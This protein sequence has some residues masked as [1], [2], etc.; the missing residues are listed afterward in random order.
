MKNQA[1]ELLTKLDQLTKNYQ[2]GTCEQCCLIQAYG[3][4][5]HHRIQK[6]LQQL[7]NEK[8]ARNPTRKVHLSHLQQA[9]SVL[10]MYL[11]V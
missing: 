11:M 6:T 9:A 4:T 2:Q 7:Q 10:G 3:I 1:T 5:T 8:A